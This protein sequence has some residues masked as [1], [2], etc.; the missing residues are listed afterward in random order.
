MGVKYLSYVK[1]IAAFALV[2]YGYIISVLASVLDLYCKVVNNEAVFYEITFRAGL[3]HLTKSTSEMF[4]THYDNTGAVKNFKELILCACIG[5]LHLSYL[6]F[7]ETILAH[8]CI[9]LVSTV[10]GLK[11]RY[12]I[13]LPLSF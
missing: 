4:W 12:V 7:P 6:I 9:A 5:V 10:K 1:S 2:F 11:C 8:F 3:F 13:W